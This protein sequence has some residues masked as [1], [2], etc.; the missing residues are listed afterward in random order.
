M[1]AIFGASG[2]GAG[3]E[4]NLV[5]HARRPDLARI[6]AGE[7]GSDLRILRSFYT[8]PQV[9]GESN[10]YFDMWAG[11]QT[12]MI[13]LAGGLTNNNTLFVNSHGKGFET[14]QGLRYGWYPHEDFTASG[15]EVPFYSAKDL[16]TVMG[17]AKARKIHNVVLA[18]CDPD[19]S[20]DARV[21]RRYFVN[22]TN[23]THVLPGKLG[24]QAM[25]MRS[26]LS[27]SADV[28]VVYETILPDST[29]KPRYYQWDTP[30]PNAVMLPPYMA[31]LF[32][33]GD[34]KPFR[35]QIAGRDLLA[36][37]ER[38]AHAPG[39]AEGLALEVQ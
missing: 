39:A 6:E 36:P 7:Y 33:P 27:H 18:G 31:E 8:P 30:Q 34:S 1:V 37:T 5:V 26:F 3:T 21:V 15:S 28:K 4:Q 16:A 17:A 23:I 32:L 29:G 10:H 11:Q 19:G 22:A 2:A 24:Y 14:P 35:T 13:T 9:R 12:R 25:F 20:F 38:S